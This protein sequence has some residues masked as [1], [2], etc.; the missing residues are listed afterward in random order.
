VES[1]DNHTAGL[2]VR[3]AGGE[4]DEGGEKNNSSGSGARTQYSEEGAWDEVATVIQIGKR[5]PRVFRS[6]EK[7]PYENQ[8]ARQG[9]RRDEILHQGDPSL[10]LLG[11]IKT[12]IYQVT[13]T[14]SLSPPS[15]YEGKGERKKEI[16]IKEETFFATKEKNG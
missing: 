2:L 5:V 10:G 13:E 14:K 15:L 6:D 12:I 11:Q 9:S 8:G 3:R 1:P 7:E 16:R 4:G